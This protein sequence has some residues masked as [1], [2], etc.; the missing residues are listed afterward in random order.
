MYFG[1]DTVLLAAEI[2]FWSGLTAGEVARAVD[3]L[4][5]A[6]RRTFPNISRIFIEA[7][8]LRAAQT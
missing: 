3:R 4:E 8:S 2:E 7:A 1:P 5:S 6:V